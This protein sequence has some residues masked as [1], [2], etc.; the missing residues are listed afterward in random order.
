MLATHWSN[1]QYIFS[2]QSLQ[3][4][5]LLENPSLCK[6]QRRQYPS[7]TDFA[8][9]PLGRAPGTALREP[10]LI[11]MLIFQLCLTVFLTAGSYSSLKPK[12]IP[13]KYG[14]GLSFAIFFHHTERQ[15]AQSIVQHFLFPC[16]QVHFSPMLICFVPVTAS[17]TFLS[18]F[19]C[20]V[21]ER[22]PVSITQVDRNPLCR[23]ALRH[24][25]L[26]PIRTNSFGS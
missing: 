20:H 21:T 1:F 25:C 8:Y 14:L 11:Q 15:K 9:H 2:I 3:L 7:L 17:A 6:F 4:L 13:V 23:R 10:T 19:L 5:S 12:E 22:Y 24:S 26:L 18:S 16:P